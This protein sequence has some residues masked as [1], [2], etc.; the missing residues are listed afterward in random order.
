MS[1]VD[2]LFAPKFMRDGLLTD[3]VQTRMAAQLGCDSLRYLP[4]EAIS[5]AI[6]FD[7]DQLCQACITSEYPTACGQRLYQIALEQSRTGTANCGHRTYE[8]SRV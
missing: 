5:R 3:D 7:A 8:T 2:E 1:K 4:V 6:G